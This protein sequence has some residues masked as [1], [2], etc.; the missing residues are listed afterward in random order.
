MV[1]LRTGLW[2]S[3]GVLIVDDNSG[4]RALIRRFVESSGYKV[5]AEAADGLETI[6]HASEFEPELIL[7]DLSMPGMNGAEAASILKRKMP[8]IRIIIFTMFEF[9]DA[10]AKSVGVDVVLSKPEGIHQLGDHLKRLL[11]TETLSANS[12]SA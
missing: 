5:C 10:I 3:V 6:H 8:G 7:M 2:I 9:G 4:I 12:P 11:G 1:R